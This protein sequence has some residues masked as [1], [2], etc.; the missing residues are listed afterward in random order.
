MREALSIE[1][2]DMQLLWIAVIVNQHLRKEVRVIVISIDFQ[3]L[4]SYWNVEIKTRTIVPCSLLIEL[5]DDESAARS[6]EVIVLSQCVRTTIALTCRE[7][8]GQEV[9]WHP[10]QVE[11]RSEE[12]TVNITMVD[13]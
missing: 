10:F 8:K 13:A 4:T 11:A 2:C 7:A 12:R 5:I 3:H 1:I 6:H 9:S